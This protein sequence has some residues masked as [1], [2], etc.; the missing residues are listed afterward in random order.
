[1]DSFCGLIA[2]IDKPIV[3]FG[4]WAMDTNGYTRE[5]LAKYGTNEDYSQYVK[6]VER[7]MAMG[8]PI[9]MIP[10]HA[11]VTEFWCWYG[12]FGLLFWVYIIFVLLRYLKQD[13]WVVP[14]WFM[15]LAATIPGYFWGIF[16][17]P[18]A[19][20]IGGI[21]FVVACLMARAV[22]MGRQELPY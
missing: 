11:H 7:N 13:C 22:R 18:W 8:I 9:G 12:I 1:M 19:N 17:S 10:V 6:N 14:Q 15:W 5:F 20:R 16:F 21:L 3:G 4:P 2:C